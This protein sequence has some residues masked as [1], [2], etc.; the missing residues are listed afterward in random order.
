MTKSVTTKT[1]LSNLTVYGLLHLFIDAICAGVIFSVFKDKIVDPAS[2]LSL[3]IVYNVLAFGL[4]VFVG[5]ISDYFK[6]PRLIAILGCF[7]TGMA[8]LMYASFP[9]TAIVFIG[10][11]NALFHVGGGSISLN[12][13]PGKAAAPGIYVAPGALGLLVGTLLAKTGKFNAPLL[14]LIVAVLSVCIIF[15]SKPYMN[16]SPR[17]NQVDKKS[18]TELVLALVMLSISV[19]SLVGSLMVFPWKVNLTL[20]VILT[21]AIALGKALGGVI[22]DRFGWIRIAVGALILSLPL[23]VFGSSVPFLAIAGMFLF[24][25]TMPVTLVLISNTLHGRPGFAFGL[26]C[27]AILLG[28][29]PALLGVSNIPHAQYLAPVTILISALALYYGI[30]LYNKNIKNNEGRV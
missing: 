18:Y 29:L 4:Q 26:T 14:V 22:A 23:I 24:N 27:L 15:I 21:V 13:T 2:L 9:V 1:L 8:S 16:Y 5:L 11:G 10:I 30:T 6:S 20:L 17:K 25:M 28:A 12:L 7:L 3:V 19:R